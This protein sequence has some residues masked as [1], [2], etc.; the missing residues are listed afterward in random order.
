[1]SML[2]ALMALTIAVALAGCAASGPLNKEIASAIPAVPA[3]KGRIYFYRA[4]TIFGGAIT[5]DILLNGNVV[6]KSERGSFFYVD[7]NPGNFKATASTEV[8]RELSFALAA[9]ETKYVK[10]SVSMGVLVG[11]VNLELVSPNTARTEITELH[12]TGAPLTK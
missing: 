11:R 4:D 5:S 10:S 1:M 6:G 7:A 3:G 9:G 8:E 12:Y 2:K